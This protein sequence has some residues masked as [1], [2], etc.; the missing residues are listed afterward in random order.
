[1]EISGKLLRRAWKKT[2]LED[3]R[4]EVEPVKEI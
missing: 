3:R 1:M 4:K 2:V